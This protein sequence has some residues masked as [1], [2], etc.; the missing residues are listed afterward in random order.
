MIQINSTRRP[1][2]DHLT[3]KRT[4]FSCLLSVFILLLASLLAAAP[5]LA[6]QSKGPKHVEELMW[7]HR[8]SAN[9]TFV[10]MGE[11]MLSEYGAR[12]CRTLTLK[13]VKISQL[14]L[15]EKAVAMDKEMAEVVQE[16]IDGG[17]LVSGY[18]EYDLGKDGLKNFL[19]F[20]FRADRSVYLITMSGNQTSEELAKRLRSRASE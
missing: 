3:I 9:A 12:Y 2:S 14:N 8:K 11:A 1:D 7:K 17:R 16:V 19:I 6:Q 5:L 18:Y 10:Q 20:V 15:F 13:P 4:D